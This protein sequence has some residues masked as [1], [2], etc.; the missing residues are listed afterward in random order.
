[1]LLLLVLVGGLTL[2]R[3]PPPTQLA[4]KA[5]VV[6]P[7]AARQSGAAPRPAPKPTPAV[8]PQPQ[9]EPRADPEPK[10]KPKPEPKPEAPRAEQQERQQKVQREQAA[11][12]K[13]LTDQIKA[14]QAA[15]KQA[16]Q[17]K[18]AEK[19][20][21][22]KLAREKAAAEKLEAEKLKATRAREEAAQ[23]EIAEQLEAEERLLRATESGALADYQGLI[24]QKVTRNWIPP[25]SAAPGIECVVAVT[26]IPGGEVIGVQIESCNGDAV[27]RR[28]IEAAVLKSSPL[29]LPDDP[30]LFDRRLR[31]TFKPEQ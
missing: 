28:S 24:S 2:P 4:I 27:V 16:Q 14:Q 13:Q 11:Q 22:E 19:E 25:A 12:E 8:R 3:S 31:F 1:V 7:N 21:Q 6:D 5:T 15:E 30:S 23:R 29:P 17:E 18:A 20:A 9:P 26:Q 10:P